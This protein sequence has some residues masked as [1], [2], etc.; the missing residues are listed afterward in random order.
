MANKTVKMRQQEEHIK[1][2][3][4]SAHKR[5]ACDSYGNSVLNEHGILTQKPR[6]AKSSAVKVFVYDKKQKKL[7]EK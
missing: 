2:A 5:G 1:K 7:V 6:F 4:V 3:I